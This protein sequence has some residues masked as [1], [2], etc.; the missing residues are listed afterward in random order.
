MKKIDKPWGYEI[1]W[2][3]T[4]KY[5]GKKVFI[6]KE[7]ALSECHE[8]KDKTIYI[9]QGVLKL[10]LEN[11]ILLL[12]EGTSCHIKPKETHQIITEKM[13]VILME[14]SSE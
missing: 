2:A 3:E 12:G 10:K 9:L 7:N 14:V 13:D 11:S 8:S 1:I 4:N 5:I 6:K